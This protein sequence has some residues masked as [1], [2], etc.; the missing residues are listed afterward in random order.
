VRDPAAFAAHNAPLL[1]NGGLRLL[2]C[3]PW[4]AELNAPRTSDVADLLG[5]RVINAGDFHHRRM[6][7][8]VFC[9]RAVANTVHLLKPGVLMVTS[10]ARTAQTS[11]RPVTRHIGG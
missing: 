6:Q 4:Q 3:I 11:Q 10:A 2:G 1:K 8:I 5:A 9:T 7:K